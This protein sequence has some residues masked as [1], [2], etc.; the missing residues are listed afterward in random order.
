MDTVLAYWFMCVCVSLFLLDSLPGMKSSPKSVTSDRNEW[1]ALN[2]NM[3]G[4]LG[5]AVGWDR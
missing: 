2:C 5:L 3:L 1:M 4:H